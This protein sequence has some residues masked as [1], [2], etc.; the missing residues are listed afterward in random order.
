MRNVMRAVLLGIVAVICIMTLV[1]YI[2]YFVCDLSAF[3]VAPVP[4]FT[5][6]LGFYFSN[7]DMFTAG[8][9]ICG[10]CLMLLYIDLKQ[11]RDGR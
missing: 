7:L 5:R 6:I 8:T 11:S 3:W 1:G 2:S 9:P 10:I 4:F